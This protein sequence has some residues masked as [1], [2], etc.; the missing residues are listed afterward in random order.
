MA[1]ILP[2]G[3]TVYLDTK[4]LAGDVPEKL[5]WLH[6]PEAPLVAGPEGQGLVIHSVRLS[7]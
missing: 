1:V 7:F 3:P 6:K 4:F 2:Q 5:S